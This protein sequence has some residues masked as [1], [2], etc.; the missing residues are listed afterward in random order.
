MPSSY[1]LGRVWAI[2]KSDYNRLCEIEWGYRPK[3]VQVELGD[4]Q[5]IDA[6]AFIPEGTQVEGEPTPDYRGHLIM[7][8][9]EALFPKEEIEKLHRNTANESYPSN[10]LVGGH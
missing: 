7:G 10:D 6:V 9:V 3:V 2:S 5:H 1:T 8:A 4:G